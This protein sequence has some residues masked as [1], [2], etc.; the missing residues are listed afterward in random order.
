MDLGGWEES[1]PARSSATSSC[2]QYQHLTSNQEAALAVLLASA[3]ATNDPSDAHRSG[4]PEDC[5]TKLDPLKHGYGGSSR[6]GAGADCSNSSGPPTAPLYAL[7]HTMLLPRLAA[8]SAYKDIKK[9]GQA[10]MP[11][12]VVLGLAHVA[13]QH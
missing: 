10:C 3:Y 2:H 5:S 1:S 13:W 8:I 12:T 11:C 6:G 4:S 9:V 7:M